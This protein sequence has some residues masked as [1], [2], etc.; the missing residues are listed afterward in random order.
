M[1]R[2]NRYSYMAVSS[3]M[4]ERVLLPTM[5][6]PSTV[7]VLTVTICQTIVMCVVVDSCAYVWGWPLCRQQLEQKTVQMNSTSKALWNRL[8]L[9]CTILCV[10]VS[11]GFHSIH[12]RTFQ[13]LRRCLA[14]PWFFLISEDRRP[15]MMTQAV[16]SL[17][18][19]MHSAIGNPDRS[20]TS[21][22]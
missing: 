21:S 8:S 12:L 6:A 14:L 5:L 3:R 11:R 22:L 18:I 13:T 17:A 16:L 7:P 2:S 9:K 4:K 10:N 19:L 20:F 1:L 15:V